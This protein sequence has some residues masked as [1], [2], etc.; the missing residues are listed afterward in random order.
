ML[1]YGEHDHGDFRRGVGDWGP[2]INSGLIQPSEPL[3]TPDEIPEQLLE[4]CQL[5]GYA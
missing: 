5:L 4:S 2:R 3:P 1:R